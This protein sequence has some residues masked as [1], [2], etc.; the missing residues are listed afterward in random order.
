[1]L[2]AVTVTTN[3][4][5]FMSMTANPVHHDLTAKYTTRTA[6]IVLVTYSGFFYKAQVKRFQD[7]VVNSLK[8]TR[9]LR[10]LEDA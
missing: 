3:V 7:T 6:A 5:T 2:S 4:T 9:G 8:R 1:M 10:V